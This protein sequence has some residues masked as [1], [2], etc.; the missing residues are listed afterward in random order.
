MISESKQKVRAVKVR[1]SCGGK[2]RYAFVTSGEHSPGASDWLEDCI[3]QKEKSSHQWR[4]N[5]T[6]K[7]RLLSLRFLTSIS[8]YVYNN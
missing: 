7:R 8:Q 6:G 3:H 1:M 4:S 2:S 5:F